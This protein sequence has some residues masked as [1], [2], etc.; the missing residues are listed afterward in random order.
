MNKRYEVNEK[1]SGKLIIDLGVPMDEIEKRAILATLDK[2]E[3]NK[4][5]A[6]RVLAI[7]RKTLLRKLDLYGVKSAGE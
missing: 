4:S 5:E 3:W 2:V 6:A 1:N 7:G